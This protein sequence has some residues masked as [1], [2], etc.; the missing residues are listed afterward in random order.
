MSK[1]IASLI[2]SKT[3]Q[4]TQGGLLT[5]PYGSPATLMHMKQCEAREWLKRYRAK[6]STDGAEQANQWWRK[7][8]MDIER[9][10]GL[11]AATELRH[12]MNLERKK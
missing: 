10:R 12:L 11:D 4:P 5:Q 3:A 8:I 1:P 2:E 7:T 6:A 9:I